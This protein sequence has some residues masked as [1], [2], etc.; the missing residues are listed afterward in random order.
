M[1]RNIVRD[2]KETASRNAHGLSQSA[3][4]M[5][6]D[7]L[8]MRTEIFRPMPAL[9]TVAT[10]LPRPYGKAFAGFLPKTADFMTQ[11]TWQNQVPV[12]LLPH[13]RI[14]SA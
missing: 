10:G 14:G 4:A 2:G 11:H 7:N 8:N 9:G 6:S 13:F 3:V 5:K 12:T 1:T